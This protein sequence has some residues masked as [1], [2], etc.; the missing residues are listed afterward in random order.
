MTTITLWQDSSNIFIDDNADVCYYPTSFG[1]GVVGTQVFCPPPLPSNKCILQLNE[2]DIGGSC[3]PGKTLSLTALL[4]DSIEEPNLVEWNDIITSLNIVR[5]DHTATCEAKLFKDVEYGDCWC[6]YDLP[7]GTT[8]A[9]T[10]HL[11]GDAGDKASSLTF[12]YGKGAD[13]KGMSQCASCKASNPGCFKKGSQ[14]CGGQG[15]WLDCAFGPYTNDLCS[16]TLYSDDVGGNCASGAHTPTFEVAPGKAM[17]VA[18]LGEHDFND[19]ATSLVMVRSDG[20]SY[21]QIKLFKDVNFG[22]CYCS[23][24]AHKSNTAMYSLHFDG[25]AGDKFSSFTLS[26]G[27]DADSKGKSECGD[28]KYSKN[29][30][31]GSCNCDSSKFCDC[32]GPSKW[33]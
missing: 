25:D 12:S 23:I 30:C 3:N 2:D 20:D 9:T 5:Q 11:D 28:C 27:E 7:H 24:G 6:S 19:K 33:A 4:G 15:L 10:G 32:M 22:D 13:D 31:H 8:G 21:C 1:A 14:D 18:N 17:E 16:V 29:K 26:Y